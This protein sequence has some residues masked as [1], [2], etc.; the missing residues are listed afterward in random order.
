M[1]GDT[2]LD[3]QGGYRFAIVM[4]IGLALAHFVMPFPAGEEGNP[5]LGIPV[6]AVM[7]LV[8]VRWSR[9]DVEHAANIDDALESLL[10][11]Q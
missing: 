8:L 10:S 4:G 6:F 3:T 1:R 11:V 9:G 7:M 2:S 5:L